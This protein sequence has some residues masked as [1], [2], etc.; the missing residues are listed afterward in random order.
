MSEKVHFILGDKLPT[1]YDAGIS[2]FSVAIQSETNRIT[3]LPLF[4]ISAS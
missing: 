4:K 1:V 2:L 3:P